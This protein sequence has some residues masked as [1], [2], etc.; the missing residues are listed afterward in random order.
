[1]L[2]WFTPIVICFIKVLLRKILIY[3]S[4]NAFWKKKI[5]VIDEFSAK[6]Q[7]KTV[8]VKCT[9]SLTGTLR[10][11]HTWS[12]WLEMAVYNLV[13]KMITKKLVRKHSIHMPC[14][15]ATSA[16]S[17]EWTNESTK[18]FKYIV[19]QQRLLIHLFTMG[20]KKHSSVVKSSAFHVGVRHIAFFVSNGRK[21]RKFQ[22]RW[23]PSAIKRGKPTS[24]WG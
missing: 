14:W 4:Q 10:F 2:Q 13:L 9:S 3:D 6:S 21:L 1:M 18:K 19:E 7:L 12:Y 16:M 24:K 20:E 22:S 11:R 15:L 23:K 8:T 5:Q 17:V